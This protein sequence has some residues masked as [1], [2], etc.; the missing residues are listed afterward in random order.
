MNA[1]GQYSA[2]LVQDSMDGNVE[3]FKQTLSR[4]KDPKTAINGQDISILFFIH[5]I[6]INFF[7]NNIFIQNYFMELILNFSLY[8]INWSFF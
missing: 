1:K 6:Q 7:L 8:A 5:Q 3:Y 2:T 4:C